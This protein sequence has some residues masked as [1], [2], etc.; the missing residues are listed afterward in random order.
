MNVVVHLSSP[1]SRQC[2]TKG[3]EMLVLLKVS[4]AERVLHGTYLLLIQPLEF[5]D[6]LLVKLPLSEQDILNVGS[7]AYHRIVHGWTAET[8]D[9][10]VPVVVQHV[11]HW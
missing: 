4:G 8:R 1:W 3:E 7:V 9:A 11:Q 2:L 10:Y 6:K 5:L